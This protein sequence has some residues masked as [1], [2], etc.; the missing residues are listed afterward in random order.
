MA[1]NPMRKDGKETVDNFTRKIVQAAIYVKCRRKRWPL[2][3]LAALIFL[4]LVHSSWFEIFLPSPIIKPAAV[5]FSATKGIAYRNRLSQAADTNGVVI[6]ALIDKGF[7]DVA[8]NFWEI[9]IQP[10]GISNMLFVSLSKKACVSLAQLAIPCHVY[11]DF[12]GGDE[13][14]S[15]M[16]PIFLKKMNTRTQFILDALSYNFTVLNTDTDVIF[17]KNPLH[18]FNC[19]DCHLEILEDGVHRLLNAGFV[20]LRPSSITAEVYK[21]MAAIA[22]KNPRTE[23]QAI[24]NKVVKV[25]MKKKIKYNILDSK[26]FMCGKNYYEVPKRYFAETAKSCD[27]CVVVHNNWIVGKAAKIYRQ[28]EMLQ[29]VYDKDEYY[30]NP[31]R[32]YLL[33]ENALTFDKKEETQNQELLALTAAIAIGQILNRTV[34]LPRLHCS[35]GFCPW[36]SRFYIVHMDDSLGGEYRESV[37]LQHPKVPQIIKDNISQPFVIWSSKYSNVKF[38][39]KIIVKKPH[40]SKHGATPS[41]IRNWFGDCKESVLKFHSLYNSFKGFSKQEETNKFQK[42]VKNAFKKAVYRQ[43]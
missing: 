29:W 19:S 39:E 35:S 2:I 24:L 31:N 25:A 13:D 17:F 37:F 8:I 7:I 38:D 16:S 32:K 10:F 21:R 11:E 27:T 5:R 4:T 12:S 30:S 28:K 14:S 41:E 42:M 40:D 23:D 33:Y 3:I 9:S 6:L 1:P 26:K 18:Y 43:Y 34:I 20:Y 22:R 15:Y 36:N